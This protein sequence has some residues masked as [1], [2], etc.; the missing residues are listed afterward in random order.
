[1]DDSHER[2][3]DYSSLSKRVLFA[4][5]L[6]HF[7]TNTLEI[8]IKAVDNLIMPLRWCWLAS[9]RLELYLDSILIIDY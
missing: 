4:L 1:V 7:C 8:I 6:L 2:P 5:Q 3:A 9:R